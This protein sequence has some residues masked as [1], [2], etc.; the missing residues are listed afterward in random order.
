MPLKTIK[1]AISDEMIT[2]LDAQAKVEG[3]PRSELIRRTLSGK[4]HPAVIEYYAKTCAEVLRATSGKL[5][6]AEVDHCVSIVIKGMAAS[7]TQ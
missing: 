3:M 4:L 5:S 1:L 6:R 7:N 2:Q